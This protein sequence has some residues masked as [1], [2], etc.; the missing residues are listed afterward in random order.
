MAHYDFT[1]HQL[2]G[3]GG[4]SD[5]YHA[6]N[7]HDGQCYAIK[8]FRLPA[9]PEERQRVLRYYQHEAT[10]L[11]RLS[12]PHVVGCIDHY[13]QDDGSPIIIMPKIEGIS[14]RQYLDEQGVLSAEEVE[15]LA[16]QIATAL[17][18]CHSPAD[19]GQ[20]IIHNDLHPRNIICTL[21]QEGTG[22]PH[23]TLIDFGLSFAAG[24]RLM[25]WEKEQGLKEYKAPEKWTHDTLT[26]A[27]DVY[28][29]GVLLF[30]LL[31]GRAPFV[32][33]D[34][35]DSAAEDQLRQQCLTA[36]VPNLWACRSEHYEQAHGFA[37]SEPDLPYWWQALVERC[38]SKD[39]MQRYATAT[40][41]LADLQQGIAGA[42]PTAWPE[43]A[44]A[45][46]TS[47][48][49]PTAEC[50]EP[51]PHTIASQPQQPHRIPTGVHHTAPPNPTPAPPKKG[52]KRMGIMIAV[53]FLL[54]CI[55]GYAIVNAVLDH[56]TETKYTDIVRTYF[57]HDVNALTNEDLDALVPHLG[58]PLKY[59]TK[60]F[61]NEADFRKYY[62]SMMRKYKQKQLQI[63]QIELVDEKKTE[64]Y[65]HL[66]MR[67]SITYTFHDGRVRTVPIHDALRIHNKTGRITSVTTVA[68]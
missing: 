12:N 50:V 61:D 26:P 8:T 52:N 62:V 55:T 20:A 67:G 5:V 44:G 47:V 60:S 57:Q 11:T 14:L 37:P 43:S 1:Q 29:F 21:P 10:A 6:I 51:Q 38:L 19:G 25:L 39:P 17:A 58:F 36:A 18:A 9:A 15:A 42:L 63:D 46:P 16:L 64:T 4:F 2:L 35:T 28:S 41:L 24:T 54:T 31:T 53:I 23:C 68:P 33:A 27:T 66:Y 45:T 34:Y 56:L 65:T 32:C 22:V 3:Q 13:V 30:V 7:T 49:Q 40:D 48:V 59:Y